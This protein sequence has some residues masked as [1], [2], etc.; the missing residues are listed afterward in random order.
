MDLKN[1]LNT[2]NISYKKALSLIKKLQNDIKGKEH[3]LYQ[4]NNNLSSIKAKTN[5]ENKW[6]FAV[7]FRSNDGT[8]NY[9]M[10]CNEKD[11][12]SRLEEELYNIFKNFQD[13]NT[14]LTC[15]GEL[16]KRFKTVGENK[17]KKGDT[18][19]INIYDENNI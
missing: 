1:Q 12:I 3:E 6:G 16:L 11:T 17:I 14:F 7:C 19:I 5:S 9:P 2:I 8:I 13:Y 15:N 10:I 4:L 18:I